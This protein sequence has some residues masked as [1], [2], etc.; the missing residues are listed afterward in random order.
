[1]PLCSQRNLHVASCCACWDTPKSTSLRHRR[2][3]HFSGVQTLLNLYTSD[4]LPPT[5][6]G[7]GGG[8]TP[9]SQASPRGPPRWP[10]CL[11]AGSSAWQSA[12]HP[13][14]GTSFAT[15]VHPVETR[16]GAK[17]RDTQE[18]SKWAARLLASRACP[19]QSPPA[20]SSPHSGAAVVIHGHA[21]P[22]P[23]FSAR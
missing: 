4:P 7:A 2:H 19:E 11:A 16:E 23:T 15:P 6:A 22:L 1:M 3:V 12:A 18:K 20:P 21:P 9:K 10:A 14:P 8:R 17:G 13:G 5:C